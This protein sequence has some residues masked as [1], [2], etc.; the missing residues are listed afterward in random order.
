MS[1]LSKYS[2]HRDIDDPEC[3]VW[4]HAGDMTLSQALG[5]VPVCKMIK[6]T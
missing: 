5:G 2:G 6:L 3:L 1:L 4:F